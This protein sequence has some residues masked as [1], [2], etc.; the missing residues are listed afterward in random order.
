ME[1]IKKISMY[2]ILLLVVV[3]SY[4]GFIEILKDIP[5]LSGIPYAVSKAIIGVTILKIVDEA[6]LYE[7][8]TMEILKTDGKAYSLYIVAYALIIALAI[9]GA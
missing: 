3:A 4:Y 5:E 2:A 9:M 1:K 8:N 6:L 7:I